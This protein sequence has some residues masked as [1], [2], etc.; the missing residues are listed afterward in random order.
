MAVSVLLATRA[1]SLQL[2]PAPTTP[3]RAALFLARQ[4]L[5]GSVSPQAARALVSGQQRFLFY[6]F[7]AFTAFLK[8]PSVLAAGFAGVI[9]AMVGEPYYTGRCESVPCP[10]LSTGSSVDAGC[11]CEAGC[12]GAIVPI[13]AADPVYGP[14]YSGSC[15]AADCPAHSSGDDLRTGCV[16]DAGWAGQPIATQLE[17]D[18]FT[19]PCESVA[20][21]ANSTGLDI[22]SG[23]SCNLGY[24]GGIIPDMD[25]PFYTGDCL[26]IMCPAD[27]SGVDV[28]SGCVW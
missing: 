19:G 9:S 26:P 28:P 20:C 22:A 2:R 25:A 13:T 23:C 1:L 10:A 21:P 6:R 18:F 5:Q 16:C 7:A 12:S 4:I 3:A 27:S 24:V 15:V 17:P 11:T 8:V 14:Y